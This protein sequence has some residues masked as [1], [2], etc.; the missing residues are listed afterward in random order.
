MGRTT[1]AL[2][3]LG[4]AWPRAALGILTGAALAAPIPALAAPTR[5][6]AADASAHAGISVG[7][8]VAGGPQGPDIQA[9]VNAQTHGH[10]GDHGSG[11][12]GLQGAPQQP[13]AA[14]QA[15]GASADS[16]SSGAAPSGGLGS[17]QGSTPHGAGQHGPPQQGAAQQT[18]QVA[19]PS[20]PQRVTGLAGGGDRGRGGHRGSHEHG[21]QSQHGAG[22]GIAQTLSPGAHGESHARGAESDNA[23]G[24]SRPVGKGTDGQRGIGRGVLRASGKAGAS[25]SKSSAGGGSSESSAAPSEP[26]SAHAAS[27]PVASTPTPAAPSTPTAPPPPNATSALLAATVPSA[28]LVASEAQP[29]VAAGR[30]GAHHADRT[31]ASPASGASAGTAF[32]PTAVTA[33]T[34]TAYPPRAAHAGAGR[35]AR[36][37]SPSRLPLVTTITKIVDVVPTPIRVALAALIALALA[38]ALRSRF[39]ARRARRLEHQRAEL[40]EDVGLLQAALLPVAPAR[41]GPVGTSVAY[42][43]AEGPGAGGDF[44]DIFALENGQLAVIVGDVSGHGRQA[45]PHT[46]L[47]RF[48]LRAYLE[49]GM[50]PRLAVQTAG[51]V[52]DRQLGEVFATV[53]VATYNPRER[54]L[55]YTCAGHPPPLVLGAGSQL[56]PTVTASA[57][58]PIGVG[59]PTGTRQTVVSIPGSARICMHTDGVTEARV[60][61]HL[62]GGE[63]LA[64]TLA[65]LGERDGAAELLARVAEQT[66][67]RPDDMAACVLSIQGPAIA[68]AVLSEELELDRSQATAGRTERFLGA[69][70]IDPARAVE[71]MCA[72]HAAAGRAGTA[73]LEVHPGGDP[74]TPDVRV[75]RENVA[76]LRPAPPSLQPT[77]LGAS[78]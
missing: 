59:I 7:R 46:A 64:R 44:Y 4:R 38:F 70:G 78:L 77:E 63:R 42:R 6:G 55:T 56:L 1:D 73:V 58:P 50:S 76:H 39:A 68:P 21:S 61:G 5:L 75:R 60:A 72:A 22:S 47:V 23:G 27:T 24:V 9:G 32:L 11:A 37:A 35:R 57:A 2:P 15:A 34:A 30:R 41:L 18:P 74:G 40:L 19:A 26:G 52:L 62:F 49:A 54:I 14:G 8:P 20:Q 36:H 51:T 25:A 43:P 13:G 17:S 67:A 16:G 31:G 53:L 65:E 71:L 29:T 28:L 66:D 69:C 3:K 12:A 45:L 33:P 48:T 10:S